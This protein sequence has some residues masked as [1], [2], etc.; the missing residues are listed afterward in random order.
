MEEHY[1]N[2]VVLFEKWWTERGY[3]DGIP[4]EADPAMEANRKAPSWRRVCKS[5]LRNDYWGKGIGFSQHKSGAYQKYLDLMRRRKEAW[6]VDPDQL[7]LFKMTE[8]V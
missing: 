1:R 5:L 2:K 8:A 7:G 6:G 3:P 4:D